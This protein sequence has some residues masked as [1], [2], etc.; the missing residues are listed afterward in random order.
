SAVSGHRRSVRDRCGTVPRAG[1]G[2]ASRKP[3]SRHASRDGES[4]D[5]GHD[6]ARASE[7]FAYAYGWTPEYLESVLSEEQL[8]AYADAA[9]DRISDT[10]QAEFDR[11]IEA[12]RAGYI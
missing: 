9:Q 12:V 11:M 8:V 3:F 1:G 2:V 5:D 6:T 4:T 10:L 7:F